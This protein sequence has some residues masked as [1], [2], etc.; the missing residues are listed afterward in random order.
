MNTTR[1]AQL[2]MAQQR[3]P[4]AA[5]NQLERCPVSA[6]KGSPTSTRKC[7]PSRL[8]SCSWRVNVWHAS[9][10]FG[11][12]CT[13][14]TAEMGSA[15]AGRTATQ[16]QLSLAILR[17]A[18]PRPIPCPNSFPVLP[19]TWPGSR[20][21]SQPGRGACGYEYIGSS[22]YA[23]CSATDGKRVLQTG[24]CSA[25]PPGKRGRSGR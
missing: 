3:L 19:A 12:A 21:A 8:D 7:A 13:L 10:P 4:L 25:T 16:Q 18:R 15:S 23:L 5:E 2:R 14:Q 1:F 9:C 22:G 6:L 17:P 11:Q 20:R 24:F